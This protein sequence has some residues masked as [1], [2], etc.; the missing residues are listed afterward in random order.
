VITLRVSWISCCCVVGFQTRFLTPGLRQAA[1]C[2]FLSDRLAPILRLET[3]NMAMVVTQPCIGCKGQSVLAVCPVECF[4]RDF[5][6]LHRPDECIDCGSLRSRILPTNDLYEDDVPD[7]WKG[8]LNSMHRSHGS[9]V[10]PRLI[11]AKHIGEKVRQTT[12]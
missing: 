12:L 11:S 8:L 9:A 5:N 4:P 7:Q 6:G 3:K 10:G 1:A 2:H